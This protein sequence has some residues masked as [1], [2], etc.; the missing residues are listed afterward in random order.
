M[1]EQQNG[2]GGPKPKKQQSKF[3]KMFSNMGKSAGKAMKKA[4]HGISKGLVKAKQSAAE[5]I[6]KV[7]ATP[8]EP[9]I[10]SA[11][12]RLKTTKNEIYAISEIVRNL[13][14]A[15]INEAHY[16][17]QLS[18][19]LCAVKVTQ[20][21]PFGQYVTQMGKGFAQ[22]ESVQSEHLKRMEEELVIP[23]EKFRDIDV[24][25]VQKLKLKY[26]TAKT[27]Y[28]ISL[29]NLQKAKEKGD[30]N[31]IAT[32]ET[33]RDAA[34]TELQEMRQQLKFQV[35]NLE[36]K[37]QVNLLGCLESYWSSYT[38]YASAQSQVLQQNTIKKIEWNGD[39]N[40][41]NNNNNNNN[42]DMNGV[43]ADDD[44][45]KDDEIIMNGN[46]NDNNN[47]MNGNSVNN[48]NEIHSNG[49]INGNINGNV[50]ENGNNNDNESEIQY[51]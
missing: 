14:E 22:L 36:Q 12:E 19:K 25:E 39:M 10:I 20:N 46:N 18:E 35:N 23:L 41:N 44:D 30:Q 40:F 28:D 51:D 26:K 50:N 15:R 47:E 4:G 32:A 42:N 9:E 34:F 49:D 43:N 5:R 33:K 2:D 45:K 7:E 37:K 8:Q 29:R 13:Y 1:A 16:M 17:V 6:L 24:E 48:S 3:G 38:S 11:L 31:K 27:N 21:D